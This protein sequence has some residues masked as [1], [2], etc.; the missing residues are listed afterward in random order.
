MHNE[1]NHVANPDDG[2][3]ISDV[4]VKVVLIAGVAMVIFTLISFAV[5]FMYGKVLTADSRAAVSNYT[6]SAL[7]EEHNEWN[8]DVRLQANPAAALKDHNAEQHLRSIGFGAVSE[9]PAI[10]HIPLDEA[11]DLVAEQGLPVWTAQ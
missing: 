6:P 2:Y 8:S 1:S 10:Y 3:E 9:S 11:L 5:S 4:K 7:A